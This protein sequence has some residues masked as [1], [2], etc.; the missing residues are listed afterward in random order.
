MCYLSSAVEVC[1]WIF[2]SHFGMQFTVTNMYKYVTDPHKEMFFSAE[3][4]QTPD[5][6]HLSLARR[7]TETIRHEPS[8]Q[9]GVK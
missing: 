7:H 8:N 3:I 9:T 4:I 5:V 6:M 1:F 2:E